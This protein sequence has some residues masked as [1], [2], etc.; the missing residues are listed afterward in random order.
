MISNFASEADQNL[1]AR[2]PLDPDL[3]RIKFVA[4]DISP[5]TAGARSAIQIIR[6]ICECPAMIDGW[7]S[8]EK[9]VILLRRIQNQTADRS[10]ERMR[11]ISLRLPLRKNHTRISVIRPNAVEDIVIA[12]GVIQIVLISKAQASSKGMA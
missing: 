9:V 2:C 6:Y 1:A 8:G 3:C 7:R 10:R 5:N 11:F 4:A 12:V